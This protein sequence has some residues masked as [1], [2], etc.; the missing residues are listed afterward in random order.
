[1][2]YEESSAK[3]AMA[4]AMAEDPMEDGEVRWSSSLHVEPVYR[5][6]NRNGSNI[7]RTFHI[8]RS[9][10]M[11]DQLEDESSKLYRKNI[12][13]DFKFRFVYGTFLDI[14]ETFLFVISVFNNLTT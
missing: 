9:V 12:V 1:V 7:I 10:H 4:A 8:F 13:I 3:E 11:I 5:G 2:Y 6:R 14:S